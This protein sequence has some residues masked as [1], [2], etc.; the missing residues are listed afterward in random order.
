MP[1]RQRLQNLVYEHS[2][3]PMRLKRRGTG[4]VTVALAG[5]MPALTSEQVR[6]TLERVRR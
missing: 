4:V 2:C 3:A 6:D 1:S 5:E